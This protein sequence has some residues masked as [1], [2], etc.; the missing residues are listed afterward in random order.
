MTNILLVSLLAVAVVS[1]LVQLR[2]MFRPAQIDLA[3]INEVLQSVERSYDSAERVVREE[4]AKSREESAVAARESRQELAG[5]LKGTGDSLNQQIL[6]L[7]AS[8]T[9]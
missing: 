6:N 9:Q 1:L 8:N 5:S 2:L 4:I 7:I 3:A